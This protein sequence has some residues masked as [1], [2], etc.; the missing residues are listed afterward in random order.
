M[1]TNIQPYLPFINAG[2]DFKDESNAWISGPVTGCVFK[3]VID[4]LPRYDLRELTCAIMLNRRNIYV[5]INWE[6]H[7]DNI[8]FS[9]SLKACN[10][11][12][13]Q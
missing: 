6:L 5:N 12:D 8:A 7:Q 3:V 11:L 9:G 1:K 13:I 4:I 2:L 10:G